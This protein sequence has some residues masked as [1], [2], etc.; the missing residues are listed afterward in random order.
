MGII[1]CQPAKETNTTGQKIQ[2]TH[3]QAN[4]QK[5]HPVVKTIQRTDEEW[6]TLLTPQQ[7]RVMR[8]KKTERPFTGEYYDHHETGIYL[9]AGCGTPLFSS[10]TKYDSGSGWPSFWQPIS[11]TNIRTQVDRSLGMT[12]TEVLCGVCGSHL[13]HVFDDGPPPTGL[14]YCVNSIALQFKEEQD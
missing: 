13:G 3:S 1:G 2:A 14:R 4:E 12:R 10:E 5:E 11:E 7:Y 9:C 8:R 6:R